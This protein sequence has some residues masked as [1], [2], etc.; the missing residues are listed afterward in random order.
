MRK[1]ALALAL[2]MLAG[3]CS[4]GSFAEGVAYS[5][6][7]ILDEAVAS[8][9]L[10]PVAERLPE[11]PK[12]LHEI[13]DEYVELEIGNYGGTLHGVSTD[14]NYYAKFFTGMNEGLLSMSSAN[15]DEIIGNVLESYEVN[16]DF[17][18]FTFRMR[19][20]L[21]WSDGEPVTSADFA[22]TIDDFLFNPALTP[23]VPK[24]FR[25]GGSASG[26]PL[27]FEIVDE[28][29]LKVASATPYG[30]FLVV[31]SIAGWAGY[32]DLLKPAHFLEPFH[33][34][35]AEQCHG[36]LDAYYDF[37]APF[38][39]VMGYDDPRAEGVWTYVFN[40]VDMTNWEITDPNDALTS[41]F[42]AGLIDKN[43]PVLYG[44]LMESNEN[45]RTV[46]VRNPYYFKVD[47]AGQQLPYV[48]YLELGF[49]EN[50]SVKLL[51]LLTGAE[52]FVQEE[53]DKYSVLIENAETGGYDVRVGK[54]HNIPT[55]IMMNPTYGL[56]ADGTVKD[57]ADS[58]AWQEVI[59]DERFREAL[60]VSID[61]DE[62]IEVYL[63][64]AEPN[65]R[66][67]CTWDV[68]GANALL[69][70][71]GMRDLDG[72]G[73]RETPS[74]KKLQW[75]IWTDTSNTVTLTVPVCELLVEFWTEIG[76]DVAVYSTDST[77]LASALSANEIPVRVY[78]AHVDQLWHHRDWSLASCGVLWNA[79]VTAGGMSGEIAAED[80]DKYLEPPEWY[81]ELVAKI[82]SLMTVDPAVAVNEVLPDIAQTVADEMYL[83][84]PITNPGRIMI[85]NKD[86][87]NVPT[88]GLVYSWNM[89]YEQVFY[90][91][92]TYGD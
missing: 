45:S 56:N 46:W 6:S 66:Y 14:P 51:M 52:D 5:Q 48:D 81:K 8:G 75:Q 88:G 21:K 49:A 91:S 69:D 61:V 13:L 44:W 19:K 20:G 16:G 77:L 53:V 4:L 3:A 22:F 33:I 74:G 55:A 85:V 60:T 31:I 62:I 7:P 26:E 17:T 40:Q 27:S 63:G 68:E 1:L 87:G 83:I 47:A 89:S 73:F 24:N 39:A 18:E 37:I 41:V 57:D 23:V 64:F 11:E 71:M 30:G 78:L 34:D 76:L 12:L 70:E 38:A 43:F 2:C 67:A 42:F 80:A 79:W 9:A 82:D 32:T 50:D 10:P 28:Y 36:S 35:Y 72:D 25:A 15:S 59:G 84:L 90:R 58:Q 92:F 65:S 54:H 29:T 86:L